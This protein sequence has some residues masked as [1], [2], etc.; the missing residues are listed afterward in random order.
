[1][2]FSIW[3]LPLLLRFCKTK[4]NP[5]LGEPKIT[6]PNKNFP[7]TK[8]TCHNKILHEQKLQALTKF[9]TPKSMSNK[10]FPLKNSHD[11][12]EFPCQKK[13]KKKKSHDNK[14]FHAKKKIPMP[15][16]TSHT[17]QKFF[18]MTKIIP[19][20][21]SFPWQK[22]HVQQKFSMFKISCPIQKYKPISEKMFTLMKQDLHILTKFPHS[23]KMNLFKQAYT[24][25]FHNFNAPKIQV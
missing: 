6:G 3:R 2:P 10:N 24:T 5:S 4:F 17:Q 12:K 22:L 15:T 16:K 11:N 1:M 8:I 19:N 20:K 14:N 9:P 25:N 13:K 18:S 7:W 21:K 23:S